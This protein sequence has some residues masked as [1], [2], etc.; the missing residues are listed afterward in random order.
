[1]LDMIAKTTVLMYHIVFY[2]IGYVGKYVDYG[3]PRFPVR[4]YPLAPVE[5]SVHPEKR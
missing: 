4:V 1:M 3:R 5:N 2:L